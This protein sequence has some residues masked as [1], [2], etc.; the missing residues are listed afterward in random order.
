MEHQGVMMKLARSIS[1]R[2]IACGFGAL[3][4]LS[5]AYLLL[6][7][8]YRASAQFADQGTWGGTS[9]GTANAQ[10]ITIPN[11]AANKPGII[12]RF[13]PGAGLTNTGP[14]QINHATQIT[15]CGGQNQTLTAA[16]IPSISISGGGTGG[17][18]AS[19]NVSVSGSAGNGN[20]ILQT[21]GSI[22]QNTSAPQG[23]SLYPITNTSWSAANLLSVSA[24]GTG[25]G[26]ATLTS[27]S[28]SGTSTNTGGQAHPILNPVLIGVRAIKY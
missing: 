12:L 11:L 18:T 28:I 17:G 5:T 21:N 26:T 6:P 22:G 23:G 3:L 4:I 13:I 15:Y 1:L 2:K 19:V 25:T 16:Q 20:N 24:S 7:P 9:G 14:T 27:L 8:P 10:T